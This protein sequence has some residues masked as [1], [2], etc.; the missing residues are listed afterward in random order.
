MSKPP[1][2][3]ELEQLGVNTRW[4]MSIPQDLRGDYRA[5][6]QQEFDRLIHIGSP[7]LLLMFLSFSITSFFMNR[8]ALF[9]FDLHLW[10]GVDVA[11]GLL[12]GAGITLA[13][14]ERTRAHFRWW[15]PAVLALIVGLLIATGLIARD[16]D[17]GRHQMFLAL[18]I[19]VIG[20][21][22]MRLPVL[23]GTA[24]CCVGGLGFVML[25]QAVNAHFAANFV[26][27]YGMQTV[28]CIFVA[29]LQEYKDRVSFLQSVLLE[30]KT[31]EVQ[32]LNFELDRLARLDA[33]SGLS[34][35]RNFDEALVKEWAR[36][37]RDRSSLALI[38][39]DVDHFKAYN[40]NYGHP[41]GDIC[42]TQIGGVL[43]RAMKRPADLAARY[44]GEEFIV[45]LPGADENGA[46]EVAKRIIA[47]IDALSLEHCASSA[48]SHVT[49]SLGVAVCTPQPGMPAQ[50]LVDVAD[51]AL[52]EAKRGGRHRTVMRPIP[53]PAS[54]AGLATNNKLPPLH[55]G[56]PV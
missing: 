19:V 30:Y 53:V 23:S 36:A 34:N 38:M 29:A 32:R 1:S 13:R 54:A 8:S 35:R 55:D 10:L 7:L 45:M 51:A 2:T 6:R 48:A 24:A 52:Y 31:S 43:A 15:L 20:T 26:I 18:M 25:P 12:I 46:E 22:A 33:L 11:I 9:G 47:G 5:L 39:L 37:S 14:L 17:L 41:A 21:L 49:A 27:Y 42:L 44:G 16:A 40:D 28:V 50:K 3:T 4:L 56:L